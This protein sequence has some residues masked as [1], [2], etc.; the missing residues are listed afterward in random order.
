MKVAAG[1]LSCVVLFL[2]LT[3]V[4]R[5]EA[6]ESEPDAIARAVA[7]NRAGDYGTSIA[8][9]RKLVDQGSAAA[10]A[11][12]GLMYWAGAGVQR[13]HN[14]ACDLYAFAEQRGDPNG[15]QLLADCY[16][17]GD[18]RPLD[19]AQSALLYGRAS[20]RGVAIADCALGNQYLRGLGVVKNQAKA[21]ILC[22]HSA[23]LGVADA[24]TDLGQMYLLGE[25]VER[26]LAEAAHW[27]QQAVAQ[28]H[29]N[30]ALM[31]G[32]MF[33]NGDGVERNR[34]QAAKLW[35]ISA[36]HGNASAPGLLA[37]YYFAAAIIPADKRPLEEPGSKAVYWGIVATRVD[38]DSAVRTASQ[39]LVDMLLSAA[40]D[41]KPKVEGMLAAPAPPGF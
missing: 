26:D 2:L 3:C 41:L 12:L 25:G 10:P 8:I 34:E 6:L 35:R 18:G 23:D 5:V 27:F 1:Q 29:A 24:Q 9:F 37:K 4:N 38:P 20:T 16:F 7:A 22:R 17:K 21:A 13:D 28:G 15:T 11:L 36:E 14:H 39:K 32:K 31:L 33:W 40:P 30:A 19:Y